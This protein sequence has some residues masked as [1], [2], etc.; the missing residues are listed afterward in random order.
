[1]LL[2]EIGDRVETA[3]C[4]ADLVRA[5]AQPFA[6]IG[7]EQRC[8]MLGDVGGTAS[9]STSSCCRSRMKLV[10]AKSVVRW[11]ALVNFAVSL[12]LSPLPHIGVGEVSEDFGLSGRGT[13]RRFQQFDR[14][15]DITGLE[16]GP[17]ESAADVGVVGNV[18]HRPFK[19]L[20]RRADVT[21]SLAQRKASEFRLLALSGAMMM[22]T[23]RST[24]AA[25]ASPALT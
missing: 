7:S 17:S 8:R 21:V 23:M 3:D 4:D 9:P 6:W 12:R 18:R 13:Q 25:F 20:Q 2:G 24:S 16:I 10:S 15:F 1:M 22:E 11:S 5:P 14:L 19:Q